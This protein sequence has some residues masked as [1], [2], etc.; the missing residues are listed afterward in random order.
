MAM[1]DF[2]TTTDYNVNANGTGTTNPTP[3][4]KTKMAFDRVSTP[5]ITLVFILHQCY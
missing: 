4:V 5:A 1:S 3:K 2:T